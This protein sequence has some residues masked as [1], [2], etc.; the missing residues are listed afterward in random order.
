[1]RAASA[2]LVLLVLAALTIGAT[3]D[4]PVINPPTGPNTP[5]PCGVWG[6]ECPNGACCPPRH[7][8]GGNHKGLFSTCPE[9][10]CCYVADDWPRAMIPDADG[11]ASAFVS[12]VPATPKVR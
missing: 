2:L 7:E 11:D 4:S 5:Y 12:I 6:V 8:C 3:C 1:M 9:G 10:Y